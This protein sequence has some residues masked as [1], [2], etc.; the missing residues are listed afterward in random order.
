MVKYRVGDFIR[1]IELDVASD[2]DKEALEGEIGQ[3]DSIMIIYPTEEGQ[4][5]KKLENQR[6]VRR[7]NLLFRH[8][9]VNMLSISVYPDVDKIKKVS[10]NEYLGHI[11]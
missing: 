4:V 6:Q 5:P 9:D 2:Y 8:S 10:Y 3:I 7:I 11:L 1:I